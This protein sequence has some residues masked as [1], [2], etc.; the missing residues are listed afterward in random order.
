MALTKAHNRMIE[1]SSANVLDF[2]ADNTG[3]TDAS[4]AIKAAIDSLPSGGEVLIPEGTYLI[5][6]P[7]TLV[8]G[9]TVRGKG[10]A[11]TQLLVNTDIEVFNSD[12]TTSSSAIFQA[13]IMDLWIN[14]TVTGATTKYDIHLQNPNI[15]R[16]SNVRVKSG[17]N[18]TDYSATNVGGIFLDRPSGSTASCF[19]NV[20]EDCW[21]QNN[22]IYLRKVTDTVIR[23]GFVW[24]HTREFAIRIEQ[25]GAI[26][27]ENIIGL[28]TSKYKGGIWIDGSAV[29]Q[30]RISGVEFDGN[31]LLDTGTGIYCPQ[32]A[33]AVTV[34]NNTFW[35]C[36]F[37]GM[38][39]TDPT[40]WTIT[41]NAFWK[42]N[43]AD[44][45]SDDIRI[46]GKTFKPNGNV[47]S[48]NTFTM[49][50]ART[51]K[52]YAIREFNSGF[53]PTGNTYNGNGVYGL[54][55]YQSPAFL[56]LG[57]NYVVGNI[58]VSTNRQ[59]ALPNRNE[60]GTDGV[61]FTETALVSSGGTLDMTVNTDTYLSNAGGFSGILS[62][63]S[64]RSDAPTQSRR[65]VYAAVGRG[66]T[67]T[68][69]SLASQDGS[70]GGSAF[71]V[72]M[73]S[74]GV[75]RFTD[76]AG[77]GSAVWATMSFSGTKSYA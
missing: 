73:A 71:T 58:G 18:D 59:T 13:S 27:I 39:I 47:V 32:Q 14:K 10:R 34:T 61:L 37:S 53:N 25:G 74:D 72:T 42:N 35:G 77:T 65:T 62:V 26:G 29:N 12:T 57:D 19:M 76:T 33:L 7:I 11:A 8:G 48:G 9:I 2:G 40:G 75:I 49:D 69:T 20:I 70:G 68:F 6:S 55:G 36:D 51:N 63:S 64:T 46:V 54:T 3:A 38:E 22:S 21:V 52:G 43:S 60:V 45:G 67:A 5:S 28:I 16:I 56:L 17:H 50:V 15:C 66:S 23:G 24:G 41:G 4:A 1:G 31:P 44:N 30:I